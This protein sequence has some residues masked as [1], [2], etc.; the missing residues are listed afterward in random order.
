MMTTTAMIQ[1]SL[2]LIHICVAF[3]KVADV[4]GVNASV[5]A[6]YGQVGLFGE[7]FRL[8]REPDDMGRLFYPCLLYTSS[9][10]RLTPFPMM[11]RMVEVCIVSR[12][13]S[14]RS[15]CGSSANMPLV[16]KANSRMAVSISG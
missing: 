5:D 1:P 16:S 10:M 14:R 15:R 9:V 13:S 8:R 2:S 12:K 4:I 3:G 7:S 11:E 6:D